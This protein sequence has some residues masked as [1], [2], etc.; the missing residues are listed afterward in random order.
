MKTS[1]RLEVFPQKGIF[2]G[3][4]SPADSAN[5]L[6]NFKYDAKTKSWHNMIGYERFFSNRN[7]FFPFSNSAFRAIDSVYVFQRHNGAQQWFLFET[8]GT[9]NYLNLSSNLFVELEDNRLVPTPDQPHTSYEP[10]GRYV[11][12][13][14]G[15]DGPIKF[16]G[17]PRADA[18][19]DLGWRSAPGTPNVRTVGA[20]DSTPQ[21]FLDSTDSFFNDEVAEDEQAQTDYRGLG[22]ATADQVNRY[23]YKVSFLNEAGSESPLSQASVETRWTSVSTTRGGDSGVLLTGLIIEIPTGP[24]GTIARRLYRTSNGSSDYFFCEQINNNIDEVF[25]DFK[26]DSQLGAAAPLASDS[27]I[28]PAPGCRFSA[29]FK[30]SLFV[31][32]G[33]MDPTRLYYSR[34]LQPDTYKNDDYF[35]VGTR[36]GGDIT[37]LMPYYNSLLVFRENAIDLIRGDALQGFELVPFIQGVGT[38]SP[39][40]IVPI[41]NLGLSFLS[42]D[43]VYLLRGGLDGGSNLQLTKISVGLQEYFDRVSRDILPAAVGVY[44]QKERELHYY[45]SIDGQPTLNLGIVYHVDNGEF[46]TREGFPVKCLTTDK[47]GNIIF[48][49]NENN[50]YTGAPALSTNQEAKG[51]LAVISG[52]RQMGT[53]WSGSAYVDNDAPQSKF[54]SSWHDFGYGPVKKHVKHV[55]LYILTK[56]NVDIQLD[57][58]KDRSWA[59][60]DG[61]QTEFQNLQR[62]DRADQAVYDNDFD[63]WGTAL[64]EDKLLTPLR[65]DIADGACTDF[66]FEFTANQQIEFIGYAIEY[67]TDNTRIIQGKR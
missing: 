33:Q 24:Q 38:L 65:F 50:I 49:Y 6:E 14:N 56:G 36:E 34:P 22:T 11:I 41:P 19:Q 30:N 52:I 20:P 15:N 39:H 67:S 43:G 26:S 29:S 21:T 60:I 40:T 54:R 17:Q 62:A 32:G 66:A 61:A 18:I 47:D 8:A 4:P 51:G 7:D 27:I 58:Y 37:G 3:I 12:I 45:L 16:R 23:S 57:Y 1:R 44:S 55:Y 9:L 59:D 35:E 28:F 64:W 63:V 5:R 42:Q 25:T 13:T 31:D 2:I 53:K 46:S 48:G 10:F